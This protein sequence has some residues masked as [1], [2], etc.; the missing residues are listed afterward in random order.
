MSVKYHFFGK[1][2]IIDR[3]LTNYSD[4]EKNL[5]KQG[6]SSEIPTIFVNQVHSNTVVVI[7]DQNSIHDTNNR[8]KADAIV[9]NLK[10]III[11]IVTAD[12]TP[13][14]L[15]DSKNHIIAAVHAG[16]RGAFSNIIANVTAEMLKIG[17][18]VNNITAVI[19]PT[20]A[21][22]SYEISQEFYDGFLKDGSNNKKFFIDGE[23]VGHYMFDLPAYVDSK[24]EQSGIRNI[25]DKETDTYSNQDT[26]FSY[27]RSTHNNEKDC[28]RN[29]SV[30]T[31]C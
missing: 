5:Q 24:L 19:G 26:L 22:K 29:V 6:F 17:A 9:T 2:C 13:I 23:R 31:N 16:W 8:P 27:R 12:C 21:Q 14:L 3:G 10:N 11:G 30:I 25:I 28:G 7:N 1:E 15:F 20:I 4:L 18:E